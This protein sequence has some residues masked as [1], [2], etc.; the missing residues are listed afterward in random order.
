[1]KP[2]YLR[3][4]MLLGTEAIEI[5]RRR[6]VAVFGLGGVGSYCVEALA[7]AGIGELTI[8]D[9]DVI[10]ETN[11]NRQLQATLS[12]VGKSK[13]E[14]L[15]KRIFDI[16]PDC[17]VHVRREFFS[18]DNADSFFD[19]R[20]DYIVD[21]IDT[22]SCKLD[23][24]QRAMEENIPII[25]SMGTGNKTDPTKFVFTDIS[26][27]E[28]CPLARIVRKELRNRGI[29][30]HRVLYSTEPAREPLPLE[31]PPP[32]RRSVPA[33]APWVPGCAGMMLAGDVI[34]SLIGQSV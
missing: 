4:A 13:A 30:N 20:Y 31:E 19:C 5:L 24:I 16:N 21:A 6:H 17:V 33:S 8:V 9:H 25:S 12:T 18:K 26:K 32:G 22:V 28:F 2:Q 27:T 34:M 29:I 1:M 15:Q 11:I 14:E 10:S 3:T 7:R 23:L